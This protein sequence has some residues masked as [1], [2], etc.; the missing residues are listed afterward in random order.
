MR[1]STRSGLLTH[2]HRVL[3]LAQLTAGKLT[4]RLFLIKA[5]L[6][7][8]SALPCKIKPYHHGPKTRE[9]MSVSFADGD[10]NGHARALWMDKLHCQQH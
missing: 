7:K 2:K 9:A 10:H 4:K 6:V 5:A 3:L 1:R 8:M